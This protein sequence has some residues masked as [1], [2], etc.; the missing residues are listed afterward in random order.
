[1]QAFVGSLLNIKPLLEI[2][3]GRIEP[4][5]RVRGRKRSKREMLDR[6]D[7]WAEGRPLR[8]AIANAN[9]P[10]EANEYA[11]MIK[12]RLDVREMA[13]AELGPVLGTL[14]GPGTIAIGAYVWSGE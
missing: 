14:A 1:M 13:V 8:L 9:V 6:F 12:E 4:C 11:E 7:A 10:E 5:G 3:D 2:V